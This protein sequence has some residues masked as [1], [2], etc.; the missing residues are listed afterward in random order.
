MSECQAAVHAAV[1][2]VAARFPEYDCVVVLITREEAGGGEGIYASAGTL[3]RPKLAARIFGRLAASVEKA[4]QAMSDAE[5]SSR[6]E[7]S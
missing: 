6:G 4:M 3:T 1:D 7:P 5:A 2:D